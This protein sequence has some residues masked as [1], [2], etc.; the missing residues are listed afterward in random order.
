MTNWFG[1]KENCQYLKKLCDMSGHWD[2]ANHCGYRIEAK[3]IN[4]VFMQTYKGSCEDF[5]ECVFKEIEKIDVR[6]MR[7]LNGRDFGE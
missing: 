6:I 3:R 5:P 1:I 2:M 7:T 4:G